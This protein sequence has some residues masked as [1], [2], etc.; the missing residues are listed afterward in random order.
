MISGFDAVKNA[1]ATGPTGRW[2]GAHNGAYR[3]VGLCLERIAYYDMAIRV[4]CSK[5]YTNK[6]VDYPSIINVKGASQKKNDFK[7]I[8]KR[9]FIKIILLS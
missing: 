7:K 2:V 1:R 5:I 8:R 9:H 4:P 3:V 6:K